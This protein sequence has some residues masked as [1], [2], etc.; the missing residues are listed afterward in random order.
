M[1]IWDSTFSV[2]WYT[3]DCDAKIFTICTAKELVGLALLVNYVGWNFE[4]ICI[5]DSLVNDG[6]PY[7]QRQSQ[8]IPVGV[9]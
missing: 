1:D 4:H 5:I 6:I 2:E 8:I 7:L 3:K 9:I